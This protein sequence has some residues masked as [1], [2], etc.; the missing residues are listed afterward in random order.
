MRRGRPQDHAAAAVVVDVAGDVRVALQELDLGAHLLDVEGIRPR[1]ALRVDGHPVARIVPV[2]VDPAQPVLV[3]VAVVVVVHAFEH[4][5]VELAVQLTGPAAHHEA[6][7]VVRDLPLTG[8]VR[9]PHLDDPAVA[10]HVVA[11]V[12]VL[13]A[14]VVLVHRLGAQA[15]GTVRRRV[16]VLG[17][18]RHDDRRDVE[19][20]RVQ[21]PGDALI[22]AVA[23]QQPV[24]RVERA[25][26]GHDLAGVEAAV[27]EQGRLLLRRPGP[28]V[29]ERHEPQLPALVARTDGRQRGQLR[30]RLRRGMEERR[31]LAEVVVA[32]RVEGELGAGRRRRQAPDDDRHP[33]GA[34]REAG[35]A[36]CGSAGWGTE[37]SPRWAT[38]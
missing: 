37:R 32:L 33:R 36:A 29:R 26:A 38:G 23:V 21:Q 30:V 3:V 18:V 6:R 16:V 14:V 28:P 13:P 35:R 15:P 27:Q 7:V 25:L 24:D 10:V 9:D 1:A 12:L 5:A 8:G 11:R 19:R 17:L 34:G 2:L 20:A 31:H 22:F 4:D